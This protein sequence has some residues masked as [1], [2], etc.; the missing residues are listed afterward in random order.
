MIG[1]E[2]AGLF[3]LPNHHSK[4][5]GTQLVNL[6][7]KLHNELDVEVFEKNVIGRAF[8]DKHGF[9]LMK[10]YTHKESGN[11]VLRLRAAY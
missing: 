5:I 7:S 8:Y 2:I 1:N 9:K 3:V 6:V 4:G 10:H 11:E